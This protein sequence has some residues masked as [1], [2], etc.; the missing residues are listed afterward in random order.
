M[1]EKWQKEIVVTIKN[2]SEME[3]ENRGVWGTA[4][5]LGLV[6]FTASVAV[7][8]GSVVGEPVGEYLV[9]KSKKAISKIS[10]MLNK[11]KDDQK[12]EG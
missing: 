6:A 11:K 12:I 8:A 3:S 2:L 10:Q 5:V 7:K 1:R 9:D 4:A